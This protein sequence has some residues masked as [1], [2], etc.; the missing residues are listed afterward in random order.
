MGTGTVNE[1]ETVAEA[2][3]HAWAAGP[4]DLATLELGWPDCSGIELLTE[5]RSHGWPRRVVVALS[6]EP[7][8]LRSAFEAGA[9][10]YQRK[11]AL[12]IVVTDGVCRMPERGVYPDPGV[13]AILGLASQI[14]NTDNSPYELSARE[15]NVLQ[16]V[17]EGQSNR[18]IGETLNLSAL[19][20]KSHLSRISRKLGTGDRA[21]MVA[22][23]MR[24]GIIR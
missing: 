9:Q 21:Q 1:A 3:A 19:T 8:A 7:R 23:V 12:P 16:L 13:A 15:V 10:A 18:E 17:A 22:L 4:C 5:L 20:V 6:H 14:A 11:S 24:A 2:R